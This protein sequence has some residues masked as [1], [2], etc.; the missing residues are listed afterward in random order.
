[1]PLRLKLEEVRSAVRDGA[2]EIDM[3]IDRGVFLAGDHA[4]SSMKL[5]RPRK[6]AAT[7]I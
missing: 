1:M 7:R 4:R 5:P 3:V 2:D 6:P